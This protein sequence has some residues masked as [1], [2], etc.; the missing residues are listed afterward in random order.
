MGFQQP[1]E[2]GFVQSGKA[3]GFFEGVFLRDDHQKE[4][5]ADADLFETVADGDPTCD[6]PG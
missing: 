5:R 4:Q 2:L 6:P 3:R 1:T